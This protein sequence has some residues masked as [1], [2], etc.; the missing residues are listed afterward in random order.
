MRREKDGEEEA[1][2]VL[3]ASDSIIDNMSSAPPR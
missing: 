3:T 1:M 2:F